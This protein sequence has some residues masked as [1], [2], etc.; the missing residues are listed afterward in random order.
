MVHLNTCIPSEAEIL[1]KCF[2]SK[3]RVSVLIHRRSRIHTKK[4]DASL[5]GSQDTRALS[6]GGAP[7]SLYDFYLLL[8][9]FSL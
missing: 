6:P 7:N 5:D 8:C 4:H 2:I 1:S 3:G 9:L